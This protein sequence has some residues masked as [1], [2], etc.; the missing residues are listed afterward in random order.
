M[1]QT[2][3]RDGML[4][5]LL[6]VGFPEAPGDTRSTEREQERSFELDPTT[7]TIRFCHDLA[8]FSVCIQTSTLGRFLLS[9]TSFSIYTPGTEKRSLEDLK[10]QLGESCSSFSPT[11]ELVKVT[12][13]KGNP[14]RQ[15]DSWS[16]E[17][18]RWVLGRKGFFS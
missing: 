13:M 14:E 5:S 18:L 12:R 8:I 15:T 6:L 2:P 10:N 7:E 3:E 4:D 17:N 1:V 9:V 11:S 16:A